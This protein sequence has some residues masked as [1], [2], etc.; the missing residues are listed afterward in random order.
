MGHRDSHKEPPMTTRCVH[1]HNR[2]I[3]NTTIAHFEILH[4]FSDLFD[5]SGAF[6][7]Q[8]ERRLGRRINCALSNHQVL[9]IQTAVTENSIS[10]LI[11]PPMFAYIKLFFVNIIK[12]YSDFSDPRHAIGPSSLSA[13]KEI[14]LMLV[15]VRIVRNDAVL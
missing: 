2:V 13:L 6:E 15:N 8:D 14:R 11:T 10:E 12:V 7:S 9:E 5:V 1:C 3:T 4:I